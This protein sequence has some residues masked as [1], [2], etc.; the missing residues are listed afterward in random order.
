M[1][2]A[3]RSLRWLGLALSIAAGV[4]RELS[5]GQIE[6][7]AFDAKPLNESL[8]PRQWKLKEQKAQVEWQ[9]LWQLPEKANKVKAAPVYLVDGVLEPEETQDILAALKDA[10]FGMFPDA[11]DGLPGHQIRIGQSNCTPF[12]PHSVTTAQRL[13]DAVKLA[14]HTRIVP[15]VQ[16]RYK[17][18]DCV[19]CS[20]SFRR[21]AAGE[22][23]QR[24]SLPAHLDE[25]S[26]VT[27]VVALDT[28]GLD[29]EGGLFVQGGDFDSREFVDLRSGDALF[30][31]SQVQHGVSITDGRRLSMIVVMQ[32]NTD[33]EPRPE[34]WHRKQAKKGH[35]VGHYLLGQTY[36]FGTNRS[37]MNLTRAVK[38]FERAM[39]GGFQQAAVPLAEILMNQ[40]PAADEARAVSVLKGAAEA[41]NAAAQYNLGHYFI[42]EKGD[43]QGVQWFEKA[44]GP[45]DFSPIAQMALGNLYL[46]NRLDTLG[47]GKDDA[48]ALEWWEKASAGGYPR[49]SGNVGAHY[50]LKALGS[51][52]TAA[53]PKAVPDA[54]RYLQAAA[55]GHVARS[56]YH[57]GLLY[58]RHHHDFRKAVRF[59]QRAHDFGYEE[60]GDELGRLREML[61]KDELEAARKRAIGAPGGAHFV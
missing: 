57:L 43:V 42:E 8:P 16:Y 30:H 51:N 10:Q 40:E 11:I 61:A 2:A 46:G 37:A 20:V 59:F 4:E 48:K 15:Y 25:G 6:Q 12:C 32:D 54:E 55:D 27:A 13:A 7:V 53:D 19:V 21:Y 17:C 36:R 45:P 56:M 9:S 35:P 50:L 60:V 52:T 14:V 26:F 18:K 23:G 24:A 49:A 41:G 31:S 1:A 38:H 3:A 47:I 22:L 44:A 34:L 39:E 29:Y 28:R 58:L 33:C 5:F